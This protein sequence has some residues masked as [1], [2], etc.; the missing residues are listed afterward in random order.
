MPDTAA[1]T[2]FHPRHAADPRTCPAEHSSLS[3][4][5][6]LARVARRC[7]PFW[8]S[9]SVGLRQPASDTLSVEI[10]SVDRSAGL[11]SPGLIQT[12]GIHAIESQFGHE[13]QHDGFSGLVIPCPRQGYAPWGAR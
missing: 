6:Q 3:R 2:E 1:D 9:F 7:T 12:T 13:S 8:F 5:C 11:L 4:L 10:R